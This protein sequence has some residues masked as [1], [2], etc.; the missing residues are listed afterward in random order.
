MTTYTF[1]SDAIAPA[2]EEVT[3]G[4][5]ARAQPEKEDNKIGEDEK[6]E[7]VGN[8][9]DVGKDKDM[10]KDEHVRKDVDVEKAEANTAVE[11]KPG[12]SGGV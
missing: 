9:E 1:D 5:E 8:D 3:R 4:E 2:L 6:L 10:G 7:E 12:E 11:R